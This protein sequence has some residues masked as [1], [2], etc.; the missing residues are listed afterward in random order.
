MAR[1][2]YAAPVADPI[3]AAQLASLRR[4]VRELEAEVAALRA[5]DMID[6]D[7]ELAAVSEARAALA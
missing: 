6:L 4:R 3:T 5:R 7:A 2:L 1:A